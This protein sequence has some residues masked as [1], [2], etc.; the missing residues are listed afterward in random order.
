VGLSFVLIFVGA[1]MLFMDLYKVPIAAS[2]GIIAGILGLSI[3]VSL[4]RPPKSP[5]RPATES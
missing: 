3:V 4:I 1:K 5:T 2:L